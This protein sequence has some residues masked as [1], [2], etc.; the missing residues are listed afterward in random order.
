MSC[1][2]C[3]VSGAQHISVVVV[4]LSVF[5]TLNSKKYYIARSV[6]SAE[7]SHYS[8]LSGCFPSSHQNCNRETAVVSPSTPL[9]ATV[10]YDIPLTGQQQMFPQFWFASKHVISMG[11]KIMRYY[12]TGRCSDWVWKTRWRSLPSSGD[13]TP[14][15]STDCA[16]L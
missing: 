6:D 2:K 9:S 10:K 3:P 8:C 15:L 14:V 1:S 11:D 5:F 13:W 4:V 16:L 12:E 7:K